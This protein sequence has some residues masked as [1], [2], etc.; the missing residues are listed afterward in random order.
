MLFIFPPFFFSPE[1]LASLFTFTLK[2]WI[3]S[4]AL[5]IAFPKL[6]HWQIR[7]RS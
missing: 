4:S 1:V 2:G 6:S 5:Y 3:K 7:L